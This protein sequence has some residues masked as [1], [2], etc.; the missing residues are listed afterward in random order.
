M[1]RVGRQKA[2][3]RRGSA[4]DDQ[5]DKEGALPTHQIANSPEEERT[6]R[7]DHE[8]DREGG[9]V[10]HERERVVA[11]RIEQWGDD[12]GEA[13]ENIEVVPLDHGTDSGRRNDLQIRERRESPQTPIPRWNVRSSLA[14]AFRLATAEL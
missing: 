4:H 13:A 8:A 5:R 10:G 6:K 3:G 7:T 12:R 9:Q 14:N 2:D 11:R 1:V